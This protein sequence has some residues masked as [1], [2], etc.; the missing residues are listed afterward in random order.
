VKAVIALVAV[1]ALAGCYRT[2]F[3]L[4]PPAPEMPSLV[5]DYQFHLSV[6]GL[7]EASAPVDLQRACAGAPP[8][9]VEE[10]QGVISAIISAAVGYLVSL[11]NTTVLCPA[12]MPGQMFPAYPPP[13]GTYPGPGG[14]PY[15][16]Q[17]QPYPPQGQPQPMQPQPQ[18]QP[19][20][21][22]PQPQ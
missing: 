6:I 3:D 11:H 21:M 22:Q 7:I 15:P 16:S 14:Q 19:Q 12:G 8:S 2:R 9:A 5:Y 18:P 4:A 13:G 10:E 1:A 17:G 20:P